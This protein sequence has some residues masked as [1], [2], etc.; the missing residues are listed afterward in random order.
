MNYLLIVHVNKNM[1]VVYDVS[2]L[3]GAVVA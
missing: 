3:A 1:L 2:E